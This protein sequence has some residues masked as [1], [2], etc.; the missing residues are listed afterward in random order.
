[1]LDH[2]VHSFKLTK[3]V[4]SECSYQ[5]AFLPAADEG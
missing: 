5:C 3:P 4:V 2:G 1:M